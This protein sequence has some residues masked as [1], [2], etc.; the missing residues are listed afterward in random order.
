M[1]HPVTNKKHFEGV[2]I[3]FLEKFCRPIFQNFPIL[4]PFHQRILVGKTGKTNIHKVF[5][6]N[7]FSIV[8]VSQVTNDLKCLRRKIIWSRNFVM[9]TKFGEP[10]KIYKFDI[11]KKL[12]L[13]SIFLCKHYKSL[14]TSTLKN[15]F[16]KHTLYIILFIF[17][18]FIMNKFKIKSVSFCQFFN[19]K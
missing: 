7:E 3:N 18:F 14:V 6:P 15:S 8:E 1:V 10:F 16:G 12:S 5:L 13:Q 4:A 17:A 9:K 2:Q 11:H 19:G